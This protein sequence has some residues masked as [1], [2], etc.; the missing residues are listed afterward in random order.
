MTTNTPGKAAACLAVLR[1]GPATTG[2]V[3]AATGLPSKLARTHLAN[4][5]KLGK[6]NRQPFGDARDKLGRPRLLLWEIAA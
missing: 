5:M 6:C 1:D 3:A 4:Q 2:E